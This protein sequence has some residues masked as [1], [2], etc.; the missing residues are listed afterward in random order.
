MSD[1]KTAVI[2]CGILEREIHHLQQQN[3]W[4]LD[5]RWLE[6]SLHD[7]PHNLHD[8]LIRIMES[9]TADRVVLTYGQCGGSILGLHVTCEE[10]I[11]PRVD[12]CIT[13]LLGSCRR[14]QELNR[15]L[16]A[17]YLTEGWL[18][19]KKTPMENFLQILERYGE[20]RG[21]QVIDVMYRN[22]RSLCLLDTGVSDMQQLE[23]LCRPMAEMTGKQICTAGGVLTWL[24]QLITGPWPRD[25]FLIKHRGE[26]ITQEDFFLPG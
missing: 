4:D 10:L 11:L 7:R 19:G 18:V 21:K 14:R 24:E 8:Q 17:Y 1:K 2:A 12:D 6:S 22:Y 23:Q 26:T 15:E 25:R 9:I 13:L 20:K 5:V 3:G 16:A